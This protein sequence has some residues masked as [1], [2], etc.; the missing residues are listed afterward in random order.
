M[1]IV[2]RNIS[3][4]LGI[5]FVFIVIFSIG[6]LM[7]IFMPDFIQTLDEYN[8]SAQTLIFNVGIS[9]SLG[10][11]AFIAALVFRI[12]FNKTL[13]PEMFFFTIFILTLAFELFR[14]VHLYLLFT[15]TPFIY[16]IIITRLVHFGRFLRIYSVFIAG[17]F[18]CSITNPKTGVYLG[19][20]ILLSVVYAVGI[21]ID[22]TNMTENLL[23][24]V[25]ISQYIRITFIIIEAL[26][27]LNFVLAGVL[28]NTREYIFMAVSFIIILTGSELLI[29]FPHSLPLFGGGMILLIIGT[30]FFGKR[31]HELYLWT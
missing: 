13:A 28:K 8:I 16:G 19:I 26:S 22:A 29:T 6:F 17:L 3:I 2:F 14:I 5:V 31:T 15:S 30:I 1:T 25:G 4:T 10:L 23:Y 18:A 12:T 7:F 27:V 21:P 20:G 11:F 9:F 24:T